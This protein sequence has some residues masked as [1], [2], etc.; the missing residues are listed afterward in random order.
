MARKTIKTSNETAA[1][2][3]AKSFDRNK[4]KLARDM[5]KPIE[6]SRSKQ[7][8]LVAGLVGTGAALGV[9]FS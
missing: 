7:V 3:L 5:A 1:I 6:S 8:G 2:R 4:D 9:L